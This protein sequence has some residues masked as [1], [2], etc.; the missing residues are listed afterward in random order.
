MDPTIF[1]STE[2]VTEEENS[3]LEPRWPPSYEVSASQRGR[4]E[5][6]FTSRGTWYEPVRRD[7]LNEVQQIK[8]N[9]SLFYENLDDGER[10][11]VRAMATS[12][13][14]E[15]NVPPPAQRERRDTLAGITNDDLRLDPED[16]KFDIYIWARAFMRAMDENKIKIAKSG[17]LFKD[18]S[19]SGSGSSLSLQA[20]VGSMLMAPFRLGE[21]CS[22]KARPSKQIIRS[23]NG[24]MKSGEMLVVLG[25]PGSGCSTFLKSICAE[26][27][28]LEL[29]Q[30]S[31]IQYNGIPQRQMMREFKG[32]VVYN[33]EVDKHFPHLTVGETLEFAAAARTSHNRPKGI[34]R[35]AFVKHMTRVVMTILGLSN[36]R[37]TMVGDDFIRGVSGGERKRVSIAE[38][39]L[40]GS[41]IACWDN[42]TRGLD[43]ATALDFTRALRISSNLQGTVNAVA[44]YQ[45]SQA[46]YDMFD[47]AIVLYEGKQIYFGPAGEAKAYFENMGWHCSLRQTTG[48]FLTSVTNPKERKARKGFERKVPRTSDEFE[49]F[50][51]NSEACANNLREMHDCDIEVCDVTHREMQ[52]KY[53]RPNS[54]FVISIPMMIF[55]CSKRA[56]HR[57]INDKIST[58]TTVI[59]QI[60]MAVV[61]GTV[62]YGHGNHTGTFFHKG[63]I[64]FFAII[65]NGLIA[66]S[67]VNQLFEQRAIVDKQASYAF[68]QPWTEALAGVI[69]D[70]PLKFFIA[71]VFNLLLYFLASLR[72]EVGPFFLFFLFVFLATL[73]MSA[74]FRSIA[75]LSKTLSQTMA[76]AGVVVIAIAIYT[77]FTLPRSYEPPWLQWVSWINPIAYAFGAILVNEVHGRRFPCEN[78]VP[79]A[80]YQSGI[81]FVCGVPGAIAGERDVSGDAWIESTYEYSYAYVWRDLGKRWPYYHDFRAF[82]K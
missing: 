75:A 69:T 41:P 34:S 43:S 25:R 13:Q 4:D 40:A 52:A 20:T 36:T 45:A 42:S 30:G 11:E 18:L 53:S 74:I 37:N 64:C 73:V 35:T 29:D 39:M 6:D 33:Q 12:Q 50:W 14:L 17:F 8:R 62:Y 2:R 61:V 60:L 76:F 65:L 58:V 70:I 77:G 56:Y 9:V 55:L 46:I 66:L 10:T 81:S 24:V 79:T 49:A 72:A 51:Q 57:I 26:M 31:K 22:L 63:A 82:A 80:Q 1:P 47:K 28:G 15:S 16:P 32:E 78:F 68:Y 5:V 21:Y 27:A 7:A 48:D 19:V 71:V 3:G 54:S 23:L 67:E 38:M 44:I 59:G